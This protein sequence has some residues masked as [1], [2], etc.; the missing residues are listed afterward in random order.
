MGPSAPRGNH[1][2]LALVCFAETFFKITTPCRCFLCRPVSPSSAS[3]SS[4]PT[5]SWSLTASSDGPSK[6]VCP[7]R[8]GGRGVLPSLPRRVN[9]HFCYLA[10]LLRGRLPGR[11]PLLRAGF[12]GPG[13]DSILGRWTGK[14]RML[15]IDQPPTPTSCVAS[16]RSLQCSEP[17]FPH[18]GNG[19]EGAFLWLGVTWI[20]IGRFVYFVAY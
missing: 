13:F 5:R 6:T 14:S 1:C 17:H 20:F 19:N 4:S 8:V 9:L 7:K 18:L 11:G 16:G 15:E 3:G 10:F 12:Q 2:K